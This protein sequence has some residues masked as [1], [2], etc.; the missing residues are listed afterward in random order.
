MEVFA[1]IMAGGVGSRFWPRSKKEKPKQLL[2]I[3][4]ENTMIQDTVN[5]LKGIVDI[6]NILI[7][8]NQLQTPRLKKQLPDLP[9]ENII[10]EPFGKNTAPCIGLAAMIV[11]N[12]CKDS[13]MMVLPADHLINDKEKF[14]ATLNFAVQEA[15]KKKGLLTIGIQPTRP[16]TGYG[17]IQIDDESLNNE[18]KN[19]I[20]KVKTFA[21]KP[22]YETA[23]RFVE[24][25][26]FLW[27]S[28]MF[29]WHTEAILNEIKIYMSDLYDG[30]L[31]IE[32]AI[33]SNTLESTIVEVYGMVKSTSIDY[34][35]MEKSRSVF[36]I[37]GEFDWNDVGSWEAVYQISEKDENENVK[38]GDVYLSK[39]KGSYIYS[40]H[41]F[42]AVLGVSDLIIID[43]SE[44][45][46]VCRR[47]DSQK[48]K[49]IVDYLKMNKKNHLT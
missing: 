42:A 18:N 29:I 16:E 34:G 11:K 36:C 4:G 5:R 27:N 15:E 48:V 26:D 17:Y 31:K 3:F 19:L 2:K 44:S 24:A 13:V 12:R 45:L 37:K 39:T 49:Q 28:G 40:P 30:L 20:G 33:Q 25:G 6:K 21:E 8:T 43:A 7:V 38:I 1:V 9:S 46:L 41:K 23:K 10:V 35:V 47:E 22:N 14:Q 32:E